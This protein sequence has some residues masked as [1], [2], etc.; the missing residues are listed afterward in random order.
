MRY[1]EYPVTITTTGED[2][3]AT[4]SG[5]TPPVNGEIHAIHLNYHASAPNTTTV[6]VDEVGGAG[7]KILDK[8]GSNTNVSHYPRLLMQDTTGANL[9]GEYD[10]IAV[11]GRPLQISAAA[12]NAL[13]A[14]VVATVV[15]LEYG[16]K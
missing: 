16:K 11:A 1:V 14:A 15:V 10:R 4:G 3:S 6:D 5:K 7:R 2:G 8:A 12:S 9:T 13:A